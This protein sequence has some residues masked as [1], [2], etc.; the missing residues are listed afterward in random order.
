VPKGGFFVDIGANFGLHT[1]L[2][3]ELVG[4]TGRVIAVEPVPANLRLLR[5]NVD[6]NG[7]FDRCEIADLALNDGGCNNVEMSVEPGL[8]L[9]ATLKSN[10]YS[11]KVQ[12]K[13]GAYDQLISSKFP[14]P[15]LV[16]ID[17]E[18]AE[19]EVLKGAT[20]LLKH[21]APLLIEV[22]R[23][24]LGEFG[25]SSEQLSSYLA[26]YGY[27]EERL[28]EVASNL[29]YYHHSLFQAT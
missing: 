29:G 13:A 4:A 20:M 25:S 27:R 17:V 19:H 23:Y 12:V 2:G 9:A 22:H 8:S 7:Y 3:C 28:D 15:N 5:R 24:E 14:V 16:K 21:G 10:R 1:L 18:G 6:L 11:Q 26:S